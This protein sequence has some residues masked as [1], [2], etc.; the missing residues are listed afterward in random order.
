MHLTIVEISVKL[1][2]DLSDVILQFTILRYRLDHRDCN[3]Q[4]P[5]PPFLLHRC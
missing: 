3:I 2:N 4:Q 5:S 1:D